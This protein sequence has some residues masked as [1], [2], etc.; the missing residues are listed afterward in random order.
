[1]EDEDHSKHEVSSP[2]CGLETVS[3]TPCR[4]AVA[5]LDP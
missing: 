3:L 1:M 5:D 4:I 2:P